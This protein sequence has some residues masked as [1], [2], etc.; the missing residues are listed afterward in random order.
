MIILSFFHFFRFPEALQV[1]LYTI[2]AVTGYTLKLVRT[3]TPFRMLSSIGTPLGWVAFLAF[4]RYGGE[5]AFLVGIAG[6]TAL[7]FGLLLPVLVALGF[8]KLG[9][10]SVESLMA[11]W[12]TR[13]V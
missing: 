9:E 2:P 8:V 4:M 1:I 12:S 11:W 6:Q 13:S 5:I 7:P 10:L 3:L